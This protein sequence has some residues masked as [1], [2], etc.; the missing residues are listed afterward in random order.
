MKTGY[1]YRLYSIKE[2]YMIF[3]K[4]MRTMRCLLLSKRKKDMTPEFTERIMLA[5]TE[6]N[7]CAIC[8]YAHTKM[9][10][11]KEMS[12]EEIRLL[13]QGVI[14]GLPADEIPG[15]MFAQHYADRRGNPDEETW[16]RIVEIYGQRK[17]LG[18][19]GAT[20]VIMTGNAFGLAYGALKNRLA[21][22]PDSRNSLLYEIAMLFI[23]IPFLPVAI[24]HM[25]FAAI[26]RRPIIRFP[27]S[28][29]TAEGFAVKA[30]S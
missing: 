29:N 24:V 14:D 6:V 11:N 3:Y 26:T 27:S 20:R 4:G 18:I 5:V 8:S 1:P 12:N 17:A 13:L 7:G 9:A 15:V 30:L 16:R 22:K 21:G 25:L 10:L 23:I 28:D 2:S 19:L